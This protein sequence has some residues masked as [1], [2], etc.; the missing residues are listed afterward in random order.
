MSSSQLIRAAI[1]ATMLKLPAIT[2]VHAY[3]RYADR[4]GDLSDLYQP[5]DARGIDGWFI[6][7]TGTQ[8]IEISSNSIAAHH[9]WQITGYR[10]FEDQAASEL[11]FDAVLDDLMGLF[12]SHETLGGVVESIINDGAAGLQL[13]SSA[14]VM[15]G[16]VLCHQAIFSLITRTTH[17]PGLMA[18]DAFRTAVSVWDMSGRAASP[19]DAKDTINTGASS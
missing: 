12:I 4:R 13:D 7:R 5:A 1:R 16:G 3:E 18:T 11:A 10:S 17:D 19:A 6:R 15:F 14:P 9:R 2:Q 8:L